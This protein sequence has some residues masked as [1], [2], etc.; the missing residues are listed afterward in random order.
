MVK[1]VYNAR[2][3]WLTQI[4]PEV[5]AGFILFVFPFSPKPFTVEHSREATTKVMGRNASFL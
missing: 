2:C 5:H 1:A 4:V 3:K